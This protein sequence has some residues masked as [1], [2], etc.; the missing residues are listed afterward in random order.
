MTLKHSK[1]T[2][3]DLIPLYFDSVK[4]WANWS[5]LSQAYLPLLQPDQDFLKKFWKFKNDSKIHLFASEYNYV[6]LKNMK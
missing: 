6:S 2:H 4:I 3:L 5:E 1:F